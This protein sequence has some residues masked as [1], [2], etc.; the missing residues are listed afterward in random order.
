FSI[1]V[2]AYQGVVQLSG[3]VDSEVNKELAGQIARSVDGVQE[4]VNNLIVKQ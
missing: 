1:H 2:N 3:F 4:V